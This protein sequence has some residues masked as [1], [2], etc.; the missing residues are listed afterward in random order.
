[1][2]QKVIAVLFFVSQIVFAQT[3][4]ETAQA[5][6]RR[7][8]ARIPAGTAVH[9]TG[10]NLSSLS[11]ADLAVAQ[12][13]IDRA[14]RRRTPRQAP[15][16]EVRLT[17]SE[18]PREFLLIVE[19]RRD[20]EREVEMAPYRPPALVTS[21]LPTLERR[22][23]WEQER[24]ILDALLAQDRL[25]VLDPEKVTVYTRRSGI[26]EPSSTRELE[27]PAVR[28]PRGRLLLEAE[29]LRV[30]AP[31]LSCR[32]PWQPALDLNCDN[33][34]AGFEAGP[35][36][37][38]FTPARNSL[39]TEGWPAFYSYARLGTPARPLH[40]LSGLDGRTHLYNQDQRPL[41]A[42]DDW[43]S[44]F[45]PAC[46]GQVLAAKASTRAG[47]DV[48]TAYRIAD[49]RAVETSEPSELPGLVTAIWPS[50]GGALVVCRMA[51]S[52]RYAAY[53][54]TLDCSR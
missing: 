31:G 18:S 32:G 54:L 36:A 53:S 26:W 46:G 50:P 16:A 37:A 41:A 14:L 47:L 29:N 39:E 15:V 28:D 2:I 42:I 24:P 51:N 43:N 1:M 4:D 7:V 25:V 34:V 10:R 3:L 30:L 49:G 9:L 11:N 23:L 13:A 44:D 5:L 8:A 35:T 21:N 17:L 45:A 19:I 40:L 33:Q 27:M 20:S 38:H 22:L 48:V 52:G 6:G 12:R